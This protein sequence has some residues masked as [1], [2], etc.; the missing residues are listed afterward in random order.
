MKHFEPGQP[1]VYRTNNSPT[2]NYSLY[3]RITTCGTE[4]L[5]V[6]ECFVEDKNILHY[7]DS[8]KCL[9]GTNNAYTEWEPVPNTVIAVRNNEE[10]NWAYRLFLYIDN[11]NRYVCKTDASNNEYEWQYAT[12]I[13]ESLKD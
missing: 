5:V 13:E 2:W 6:G 3:N 4:H 12:S 7:N 1:V 9:I 8:T 11:S 10:S